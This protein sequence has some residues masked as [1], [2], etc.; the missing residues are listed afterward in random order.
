MTIFERET[1]NTYHGEGSQAE[2]EGQGR[3]DSVRS[4]RALRSADESLHIL[5]NSL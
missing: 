5:G 2:F 1:R 4:V 3:M